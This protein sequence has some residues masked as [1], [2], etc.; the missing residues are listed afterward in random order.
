M[1]SDGRSTTL[2]LLG[3]TNTGKTH[4]AIERMLEHGS[5]MLGLP[6]RLLAREVYDK[7]TARI[8]ERDVALVTGEE[9]RIPKWPR[10]W[11]CTVEAMPVERAVEFL[12]VDEVQL[13]AHDQRGHVFTERL[14][15]ARG[16]RET[17]FLGSHTM[18]PLIGQ[19]VPTAQVKS[20]PRLSRLRGTGQSSLAALPPRSAVVAFSAS[21]VYEIA[22]RIRQKR[23]GA[24]V[25]LGALSPRARN[26]QVALYQAGEVDYLVATDAIGMGLNLDIGHVAFAD[27][28]KFDGREL[29]RLSAAELAQIA[30]RAGRYLNDGTFGSLAPL[31]PIAE[32]IARAIET[33]VFPHE[34]SVWWRNTELDFSSV[35]ALVTSLRERPRP[36]YL[37]LAE[38][39]EDF[40]ALALLSQR[41]EI[42]ARARNAEAVE[43]LWNVCRIPDYRGLLLDYHAGLLTE[44]FLQLSGESGRIDSDWAAARIARLN[45]VDGDID[46]LLMRMAF[47]RTWTYISHQPGWLADAG[48]WQERA[49]DIEDRLSDALHERLVARFV[50]RAGSGKKL[51]A[52]ATRAGVQTVPPD[53]TPDPDHPFGRLL[54]LRDELQRRPGGDGRGAEPADWLEELIAAPHEQFELDAEGRIFEGG[55]LLGHMTR[56]SDLLRP[57]VLVVLPELG[58]G[59]RSRLQRR[60]L[61][62]TRDVISDLLR[63]LRQE[64]LSGLSPAG[65][66]LVYQLERTLGTLRASRAAPQ[67]AALSGMDR[68][69]L[70]GAGVRLRGPILHVPALLEPEAV[71]R[72]VALWRAHTGQA[73]PIPR[74]AASVPAERRFDAQAYEAVGYPIF[75]GRGV[76]ADL[77]EGVQ[78]TLW[79]AS[80]RGSFRAPNALLASLDCGAEELPAIIR[81]FG[82]RPLQGGRF[83]AKRFRR[84]SRRSAA[85]VAKKP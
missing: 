78:A 36:R 20:H 22:E 18:Q 79:R 64:S 85:G 35:D 81:A 63:P 68:E 17:W 33:H 57:E 27:L 14:R 54:A 19:L 71:Q 9:K 37:R 73:L 75:G 69:L 10:Y 67:L 39:A 38:K 1:A 61:A 82:Y 44:L 15:S 48:A 56:G 43:L 25:V 55:Q 72:R 77:I 80:R 52:R 29:R 74:D 16:T 83:A 4:R 62:F 24:A 49:R 2:A 51:R 34:R 40:A 5:G 12:A 28:Q 23:G 32:P 45:D 60:L 30:G 31:P 7:V 8:G 47:I 42:R 50:D 26:A 70:G 13:A 3:P 41:E 65:R 46:T 76:R 6:L 84:R 11:I 21:R 59:D 66:G 58:S 53:E